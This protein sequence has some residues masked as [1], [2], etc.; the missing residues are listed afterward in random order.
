[1][2][3]GE[4]LEDAAVRELMEETGMTIADAGRQVARREAVLQ[5]P[6]GEH[7]LSDERYF[8]VHANEQTVQRDGWSRLE[9]EV[10]TDHRWWSI[11]DLE[12]TNDTVWPKELAALLRSVVSIT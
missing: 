12:S 10:M 7:V 8:V 5:L 3:P 6:D 9:L 4:T 1:M 2:E 11:A